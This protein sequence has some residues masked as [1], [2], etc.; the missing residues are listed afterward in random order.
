MVLLFFVFSDLMQPML[1]YADRNDR[2]GQRRSVVPYN[3]FRSDISL[4]RCKHGDPDLLVN[5]NLQFDQGALSQ[6]YKNPNYLS[7]QRS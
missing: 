4:N 7:Y 5:I 1:L 3:L 2:R 6:S